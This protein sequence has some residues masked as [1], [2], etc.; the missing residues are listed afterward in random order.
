MIRYFI[1]HFTILVF[2]GKSLKYY[3]RF[4]KFDW[5]FDLD[6]EPTANSLKFSFINDTRELYVRT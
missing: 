3:S 6:N 4:L 1:M 2:Q 5:N